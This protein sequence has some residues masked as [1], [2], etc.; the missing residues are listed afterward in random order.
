[1]ASAGGHEQLVTWLLDRRADVNLQS[2]ENG[3]GASGHTALMLAII[4]H[5]LP[6]VRHLISAGAR[7]DLQLCCCDGRRQ[8]AL[9]C[10][11]DYCVDDEI[12]RLVQHEHDRLVEEHDRAERCAEEAQKE[13][14]AAS[15]KRRKKNKKHGGGGRAAAASA[16]AGSG[17]ENAAPTPTTVEGAGAQDRGEDRTAEVDAASAALDD[18]VISEAASHKLSKVVLDS[19]SVADAVASDDDDSDRCVVCFEGLK[20]HAMILCGHQCVCGPCGAMIVESEKPLCPICREPVM[21]AV[22]I[23]KT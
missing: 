15:K 7:I 4:N 9:D 3:S 2:G 12:V 20:T 6:V 8:T 18:M 5:S 23:F 1:M 22:C 11:L 21:T 14:T 10:A 16:E 13:S 17:D 19:S